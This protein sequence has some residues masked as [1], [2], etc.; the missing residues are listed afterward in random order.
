MQERGFFFLTDDRMNIHFPYSLLLPLLFMK[1]FLFWLLPL[2]ILSF[3]SFQS[4]AQEDSSSSLTTATIE[5]HNVVLYKDGKKIRTLTKNWNSGW[6]SPTSEP[7][8]PIIRYDI[9][10]S[11]GNLFF[12]MRALN[13]GNSGRYAFRYYRVDTSLKNPYLLN[14]TNKLR[15]HLWGDPIIKYNT[16]T[17][18]W[19][20]RASIWRDAASVK[21]VKW[22]GYTL[23]YKASDDE[24]PIDTYIKVFPSLNSLLK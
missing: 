9:L 7:V 12:I 13:D 11:E 15:K 8:F 2:S 23:E 1:R 21:K 20:S 18:K 14:I 19:E 24:Q 4:Y 16:T 3:S 17:A 22:L 10:W 5:N 6:E